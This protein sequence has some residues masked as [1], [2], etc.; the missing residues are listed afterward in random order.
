MLNGT[1]AIGFP[2]MPLAVS[3]AFAVASWSRL[4][5][6]LRIVN[7]TFRLMKLGASDLPFAGAL[8]LPAIGFGT[9]DFIFICF[10]RDCVLLGSCR[11]RF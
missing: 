1:E 3:Q 9:L 7:V 2:P 6:T 4:S 5:H 11:F 10:Y 8:G